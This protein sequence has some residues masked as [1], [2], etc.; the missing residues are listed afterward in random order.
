MHSSFVRGAEPSGPGDRTERDAAQAGRLAAIRLA[1]VD[2]PD[3]RHRVAH[4][5]TLGLLD[6]ADRA[7]SG[8]GREAWDRFVRTAA[9]LVGTDGWAITL[10]VMANMVGVVHLGE[11]ADFVTASR[12]TKRYGH[13]KVASVQSTADELL[14]TGPALPV[15]SRWV[16]VVAMTD[17]IVG[18]LEGSG[19]EK[20]E[21]T[22]IAERCYQAGFW[23]V[24]ADIDPGSPG[25]V[26]TTA[27][28]IQDIMQ[29]G[30]IRDW[31]G[32]FAIIA[33]NP[34]TPYATDLQALAVAAGHHATVH[35]IE[36]AVKVYRTRFERRERELVAR[37]IRRLVAVSGLSQ[38]E[39]AGLAGTSASRLS[40]YVNGL[41]TPSATLMLR[42]RR[43]SELARR[44]AAAADGAL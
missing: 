26:L 33:D 22:E 17:R 21:A 15:A 37:E 35:A 8:R 39:F 14:G 7:R 42:I 27:E 28:Q 13:R 43:V 3:P 16:L 4:E 18:V 31:R 23:L 38:R 24:M 9:V 5:A 36:G 1:I 34:W 40:T 19:L 32:Q 30:G 25:P 10:G 12:L 11:A 44:Q 20:D 6:R 2:D 29:R 41:V